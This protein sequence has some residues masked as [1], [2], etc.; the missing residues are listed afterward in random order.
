MYKIQYT[1]TDNVII[2][3]FKKF[4]FWKMSVAQMRAIFSRRVSDGNFVILLIVFIDMNFIYLI[5]TL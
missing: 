3:M 2:F 5:Y 4:G 1:D